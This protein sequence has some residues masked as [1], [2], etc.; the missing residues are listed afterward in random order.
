MASS[1]TRRASL[2][3]V[4]VAASSAPTCAAILGPSGFSSLAAGAPVG[5]SLVATSTLP[6]TGFNTTANVVFSGVETSQV[7]LGDAGSP[8]GGLTFV[9]QLNNSSNSPDAI[10]RVSLSDFAGFSTQVEFFGAGVAPSFGDRSSTPGDIVGF[11]FFGAT[12][13]PGSTTSELVIRTNALQFTNNTMSITDGGDG[14]V[15]S[16]GGGLRWHLSR[17]RLPRH[18]RPRRHASPPPPPLS[19]PSPIHEPRFTPNR[20]S[21]FLHTPRAFLPFRATLSVQYPH[22][23][24]ASSAW[25]FGAPQRRR[26][27]ASAVP[28][29]IIP[30]VPASGTA[31]TFPLTAPPVFPAPKEFS[32]SDKSVKSIVAALSKFPFSHDDVEVPK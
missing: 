14:V 26:R 11:D 2:V 31:A 21:F 16:F 8:F 1:F 28:A 5:G 10:D 9:Y 15:P 17:T 29:S 23:P 3:L 30:I 18:H 24:S 27:H 13:T 25:G 32:T 20:G 19:H 6:Y 7:F 22:A 12:L 4:L